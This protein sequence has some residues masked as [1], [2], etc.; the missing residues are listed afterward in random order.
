MA[1]LAGDRARTA[2]RRRLR[3]ARTH[4]RLLPS[5]AG[6]HVRLGECSRMSPGRGRECRQW[7]KPMRSGSSG[8]PCPLTRP[9]RT[10]HGL[11]GVHR[12]G[13]WLLAGC[14]TAHD[15]GALARVVL[16]RNR[17]GEQTV[18]E[19][20][21]GRR[22]RRVRKACG[23][24]TERCLREQAHVGAVE[25]AGDLAVFA[26]EQR[27]VWL[28]RS[29]E[30]IGISWAR[31]ARTGYFQAWDAPAR[32]TSVVGREEE[33]AVDEDRPYP[34]CCRQARQGRLVRLTC[35]RRIAS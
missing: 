5:G 32:P 17:D 34:S 35:S 30:A 33:Q 6:G 19:T 7:T 28:R 26:P 11:C 25:R 16:P 31:A 12:S 9:S 22:L 2:A 4:P 27:F 18:M 13:T 14:S 29:A 21:P 20:R 10:S 3:R 8:R 15:C 24:H 23:H 1:S